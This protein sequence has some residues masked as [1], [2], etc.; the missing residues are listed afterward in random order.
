MTRSRRVGRMMPGMFLEGPVGL[1]MRR[2]SI[3]DLGGGHQPIFNEDG[4]VVVVLQRRD[5]Q[6]PG[7]ACVAGAEGPPLPDARRHR[8][9]RAPVRRHGEDFAETS[10]R[11]VR[12]RTLRPPRACCTS[13]GTGSESSHSMWPRSTGGLVFGSEI[14]ALMASRLVLR[15]IS[16]RGL[17]GYLK[18]TF[19]PG[20]QSIYAGIRQISRAG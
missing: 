10:A 1:A 19:V 17:R 16:A 12:D 8:S 5:L 9:H 3:I 18:Y 15:A 14:K 2:L 11:D 13:S 7:A 20:T 6:L 4:S